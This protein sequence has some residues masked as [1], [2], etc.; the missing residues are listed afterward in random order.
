MLEGGQQQAVA[1]DG[2]QV[3][4]EAAAAVGDGAQGTAAT[5]AQ[6][7]WGAG[8]GGCLWCSAWQAR[9]SIAGRCAACQ[10]GCAAGQGLHSRQVCSM[11]QPVGNVWLLLSMPWT[12]VAVVPT[13]FG[14]HS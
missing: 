9:A 2:L 11:S 4:D 14:I 3:E 6:G 8:G 7:E 10:A 13:Q 1:A 5:S 12:H